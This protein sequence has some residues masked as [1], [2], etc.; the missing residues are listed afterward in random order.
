NGAPQ[1]HIDNALEWLARHQDSDGRWDCDGFMKH[2]VSGEPCSGPGNAVHDV[3]VTGL[4]LLALLGDGSSLRQGRYRDQ[5]RRAALWLR[6]QQEENGLIGGAAASD[7]IYD[8]AIAA[9]ALCEAYGLSSYET[10]RPAAQKALDYLQAHR[11]PYGA[12][13]YQ[14][15]DGDSDTSITGWCVLAMCSGKHFGLAVDENALR[16]AETWLAS[17]TAPDGHVGYR[18]A[19]E[20]SARKPGRHATAFPPERTDAL[21]AVGL[22]CRYFLGQNPAEQSTMSGAA[23]RL[24]SRQPTWDQQTGTVDFYYWYYGTYA[25]FQVGGPAW[26]DW[27]KALGKAVLPTQHTSGNLKGSWDPIDAWGEDGGRV[28]ST[29]LLALTLQVY[30]RYGRLV[31]GSR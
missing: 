22:F 14:P 11:N 27:S 10:L 13:R 21:T 6:Q 30:Y 5:V 20:L 2:D 23:G 12:W 4:A 24:R 8:H 31:P 29:A 9:Y 25:M 15:R 3:G 28:Y 1:G 7:F 17:C 26:R 19:G 16:I 18:R